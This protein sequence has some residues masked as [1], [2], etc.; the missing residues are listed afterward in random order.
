MA[1]LL[2]GQVPVIV[3]SLPLLLLLLALPLLLLNL[4][5]LLWTAVRRLGVPLGTATADAAAEQVGDGDPYAL[6][7]DAFLPLLLLR[8]LL[9]LR[10]LGVVP[11]GSFGARGFARGAARAVTIA[12]GAAG[13]A[14]L[15]IALEAVV[16]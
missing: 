11:H 12:R 2:S 4:N 8:L 7:D 13:A 15:D 6:V 5:L 3:G 16:E 1:D 9:G 14:T 10:R